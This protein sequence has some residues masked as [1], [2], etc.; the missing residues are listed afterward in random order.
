MLDLCVSFVSASAV[1]GGAWGALL[2]AEAL[3]LAA[4]ATL[5]AAPGRVKDL[6]ETALAAVR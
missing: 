5:Y 2:R 4:D 1:A 6:A 3:R